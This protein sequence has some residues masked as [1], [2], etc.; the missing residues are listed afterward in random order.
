[1]S[2]VGHRVTRLEAQ[3]G[4]PDTT[5]RGPIIRHPDGLYSTTERGKRMVWEHLVARYGD[6]VLLI[7][8][9]AIEGA[10]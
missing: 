3:T 9:P 4:A 6:P 1:M 7:V 10:E 5:P 2:D 8:L